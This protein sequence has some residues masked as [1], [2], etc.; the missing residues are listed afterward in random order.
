MPQEINKLEDLIE[1][2]RSISH[3]TDP[4]ELHVILQQVE[5]RSFGAILI[6]A[7]IIV[8]APL[9]GDIPGV[10]T[11]VAVLVV[12]TSVQ[13]LAGRSYFWLPQFLLRRSIAHRHLQ[14]ALNFMLRPAR[15]TDRF[16]FHRLAFFTGNFF[17]LV[18]AVAALG[19]GLA[20]PL[21]EFI[22]FSAN[23]AGIALFT[24]GAALVV[25]DGLFALISLVLTAAVF[26][27]V[28]HW[29]LSA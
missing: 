7:G 21:L 22:P 18:V 29:I 12:L 1:Q 8:L 2:L 28:G 11:L 27:L 23:L 4:V 9:V 14:G 26:G 3:E 25:R 19:V 20:M 13:I 5:Q 16:L 6:V 24:F 17:T 15:F 10:P